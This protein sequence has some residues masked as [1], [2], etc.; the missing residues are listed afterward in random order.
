MNK[1][2][3]VQKAN[4]ATIAGIP[5]QKHILYGVAMVLAALVLFGLALAIARWQKQLPAP[6]ETTATSEMAASASQQN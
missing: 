6:V 4:Q 5:V 2:R 3:N 1:K